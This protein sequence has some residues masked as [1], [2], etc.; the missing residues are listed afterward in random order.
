MWNPLSWVMEAIKIMAIVL[1]NEN[2]AGNATAALM[3]DHAPKT[4]VLRNGKWSEQEATI[5]VP[6][7]II[8]IKLGYI[9][10]TDARLLEGD[11]LKIDQSAFTGEIEV[12]FVA[13]SG[14]YQ[15]S[16]LLWLS[17][18]GAITKRMT[19]IEEMAS[20]DIKSM[21]S[22]SQQE[23]L[24][25]KI[26]MPLMLPLLELGML[27]DPEDAR[28]GIREMHFLP[29]SPVDK[30]TVLTYIDSNCNWHRASKGSPEQ[31]LTLC[32]AKEDVKKKV[33]SIIDK[34]ADRGLRSLGVARQQVPEKTK[35][36][37]GTPW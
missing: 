23:P 21:L 25:L 24:E 31:I 32:N 19:A 29:F 16:H 7:D 3:A 34:F 17:Q 10:P 1:A 22:C 4:N 11:P 13:T 27:V 30:R 35:E 33:H 6:G 18:Q 2:N 14:C 36:D 12:V 8:N 28:A 37:A 26:K 9:V 20:M 15:C 5:L